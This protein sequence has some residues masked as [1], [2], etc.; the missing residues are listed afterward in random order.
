ME[1][2]QVNNNINNYHYCTRLVLI[3]SSQPSPMRLIHL[4]EDVL[5]EI[6]G[7]LSV[8]DVLSLKQVSSS[9]LIA[10]YSLFSR[11]SFLSSSF[12]RRHVV[13]YTLSGLRIIYGIGSR[14]ESTSLSVYHPVFPSHLFRAMSCNVSLSKRCASMPIG[15]NRHQ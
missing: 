3:L 8:I 5:L 14:S 12:I 4:P 2:T 13:S 7:H 10:V 1:R 15:A 11:P 9:K 6:A